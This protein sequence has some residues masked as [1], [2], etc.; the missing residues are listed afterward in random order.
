MNDKMDKQAPTPG[1]D[2][3]VTKAQL[4]EIDLNSMLSD[5]VSVDC[6]DLNRIISEQIS[7]TKADLRQP[8]QLLYG[9]TNYH[10]E[11]GHRTNPFK[12]MISMS[13][14][15]TLVPTDL[16]P[17]QIDVLAEL[18]P[19]VPNAGL[20]AR[21]ADVVWF[22]QRMRNDI[23]E[24]AVSAYCDCMEQLRDGTATLAFDNQSPWTGRAIELLI[25]A[26]II[27]QAIKW[28]LKS[29]MRL[30]ELIEELVSTAYNDRSPED[31]VRIVNFEIR[32]GVSPETKKIAAWSEDL[33]ESKSLLTKPDQRIDLWQIATQCYR[34]MQDENNS[35]R[36]M[37]EVGECYVQ[38]AE[39]AE[40]S[41]STAHFLHRAIEVL[42]NYPGTKERREELR[43]KLSQVQPS[44]QDEMGTVSTEVDLTDLAEH[45]I[46]SVQGNSWSQ[47]FRYM[48]ICTHPPEPDQVRSETQKQA[49]AAPLQAMIPREVLDFQGRV[50]FR[51][52]GQTENAEEGDLH[53]RHL[54]SRHRDLSRQLEVN[55]AIIPV[56]TVIS[57]E[58]LVSVDG[59]LEMIK[60]SPF[61]PAEHVYI[62]A[63]G[64]VQF[65][66]GED[67]EA[68]SL[69]VPQL[70]N[71]LRHILAPI[72]IDTATP[73]ERG[74]QTEASLS[75]LLNS[76]DQWRRELERILPQRYI[77]EIDLLFN[78]AGGPSIR[79]QI[80]HGKVP[81]SG[82]WNHNM[83]YASWLII[84]LAVLPLLRKWD[85]GE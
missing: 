81:T 23:A 70:E 36:C 5:T 55:G 1:V 4:E 46:A 47:A 51:S 32:Y 60:D 52:P 6:L 50:M 41:M 79:N 16:L 43:V 18:A 2:F 35:N 58:H 27:S 72:G 29:C 17:E 48:I 44:I 61:I 14:S 80:A 57:S 78:F 69:L 30:R 71:S 56:R 25:R 40:S 13:D 85:D 67:V 9:L 63:R 22:I 24:T 28:K 3:V 21:M 59:V 66:A 49:N 42:R 76:G 31:F 64:I 12:P 37:V 39:L 8:L 26:A 10:V 53:F 54:M 33:V 45:H 83:V 62:F 77:H 75:R 68:A 15:R 74:I 82:F 11:P 34:Y 73:D 19:S 65:L 20:R 7:S 38:R 84:R